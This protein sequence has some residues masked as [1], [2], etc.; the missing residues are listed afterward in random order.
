MFRSLADDGTTS[1]G[2]SVKWCRSEIV[3]VDVIVAG[4]IN[5]EVLDVSEPC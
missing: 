3:N 5:D 2:G 4:K 1:V